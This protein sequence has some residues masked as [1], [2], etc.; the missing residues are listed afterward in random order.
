MKK[1]VAVALT[2]Y[3]ALALTPTLRGGYASAAVLDL[4]G[5]CVIC[6]EDCPEGYHLAANQGFSLKKVWNRNG[7]AHLDWECRTGSCETKHGPE[8]CTG[9]VV[10]NDVK[11]LRNAIRNNDVQTLHA[12]IAEHPDNILPNFD[13][14]AVQLAN[15]EG[16]LYAHF[17]ANAE[18]LGRLAQVETRRSILAAE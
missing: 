17:P 5:D 18:L 3:A 4:E 13:R 12:L 7:G 14:A 15:C 8:G 11:E 16:E 2:V 6:H 9:G 10:Y 1:T